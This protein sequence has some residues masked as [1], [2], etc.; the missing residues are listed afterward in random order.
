MPIYEYEPLDRDCLMCEGKFE[1]IQGVH[2][3][4][5]KLCPHCGLP[6]RRLISR[7]SIKVS[8]QVSADAAA[9]KGFSTF[10]RAQKGVWEKVAGP[11][12]LPDSSSSELQG[13]GVQIDGDNLKV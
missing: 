3:E 2:D 9:K 10:R 5:H 12:E 4:A 7:A 8:K 6:V 11:D 1:A 13:E